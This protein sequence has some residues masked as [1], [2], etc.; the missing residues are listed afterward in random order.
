MKSRKLT[1][2]EKKLLSEAWKQSENGFNMHKTSRDTV[3]SAQST[4][5]FNEDHKQTNLF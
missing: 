1:P 3:K 2:T 4:P 5:L